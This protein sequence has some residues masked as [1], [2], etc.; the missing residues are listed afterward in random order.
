[1]TFEEAQAEY[2]R[3]RQAYDGRVLPPE[4]YARR[5]QSLQVR[6]QSGSYW[7][8]DGATGGWLRYNGTAW[9]PG[10][11]PGLQGPAFAPQPP[12][13]YGQPQQGGYG[14]PQGGQGYGP[15]PQAGAPAVAT[16]PRR[17]NRGLIAGC[18]TAV[19]VS[20][21]ACG[22]GSF[23]LVRS[24]L[25]NTTAG[26]TEASVARSVT[27]DNLPDA[28]ADQFRVA[29]RVYVTYTA[30][31][32]RSGDKVELR[33]FRNNTPVVV[34]SGGETVFPENGSFNG[35]FEYVPRQAGEY[36]AELRLNGEEAPTRTVTFSV[37]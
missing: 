29:E 26:I 36:Q 17:S 5:I 21:L 15:T 3:L 11:P 34:D 9:V 25:F 7:A 22:I 13:G 8:I 19:L 30:Q 24:G 6:D 35:Y 31:R 32:V 27:A 33:L 2:I 37:R 23:L 16:A 12:A 4:E 28:R 20:L 1:M 10:Q 14:Y 18:V